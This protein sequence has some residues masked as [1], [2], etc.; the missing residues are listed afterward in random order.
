MTK[1][2]QRRQKEQ[3][4]AAL[5]AKKLKMRQESLQDVFD[6]MYPWQYDFCAYSAD[7]FES[8]LCA[9]NQ[10]GKTRTGT[11]IDAYHLIGDYPEDWPGHTFDYPPLCWILSVTMEKSRDLIQKKLFGEYDASKQEFPGGLVPKSLIVKGRWESAAGTPNAMRTVRVKHKSGGISV[12]QFWSYSQGKDTFMGDVIDWFH[13]DEEPTAKNVYSQIQTRAT[14]GDGGRGGRGILTFTPENGLTE[15]VD[16]FKNRPTPTQIY[17]QKGWKDAP[18]IDPEKEAR[19]KGAL[20]A[21]ELLMRTEGEPILVKGR[22]Y[23]LA[24]DFVECSMPKIQPDWFVIAGCDFGWDHPQAFVKL[25][26]DRENDVIYVTHSW[27]ARHTSPIQA[28]GATKKWLGPDV[29]IAWPHDGWKHEKQLNG[30]AQTKSLYEDAGFNMLATHSTWPEGGYAVEPGLMEINEGLRGRN[31]RIVMGQ[32]DFFTEFRNYGRDDNGKIVK[33][34]DDIMDAF[35][36][37]YMMRRF[38]VQV[39]HLGV[40]FKKIDFMGWRGAHA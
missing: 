22:I 2:A 32:T 30:A 40:P 4:L 34:N 1:T 11:M 15:L 39:G 24:D 20:P 12:V 5:Q 28:Y 38:A 3:L 9:G 29:P 31:I 17:M 7:Y 21:H 23:Q 27:K 13:I 33:L 25:Y 19:Q 18:H 26:E 8:C 16:M 35:R 14:N 36:I 37:A 10:I 6:T